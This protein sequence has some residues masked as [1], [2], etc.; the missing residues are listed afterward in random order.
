VLDGRTLN[1][2]QTATMAS[3]GSSLTLADNAV[4]NNNSGASWNLAADADVDGPSGAFN[5]SGTF[6]KTGGTKTST[7]QPAFVNNGAVQANAAALIFAG[8]F[9]Q[10]TGS[11]S[12]G[13][14]A[15][16]VASPAAFTGGSL[17]GQ[18]YVTGAVLNA[19]AIV[20]PGTT[21]VVGKINLTG[22]SGN[23]TQNASGTLRVK[24]GGT[25]VSQYDQLLASEVVT[26]GGT[27]RVSEINGFSPSQG[28]T[29]T[30]IR[31]ASITGQFSTV[32]SGWKVTYKP[33]SVVLTFQ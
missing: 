10:K 15:M 29:F 5:N 21:A 4:V 7:I 1:N 3:K 25:P 20:A 19:S 24:I 31:G 8:N 2:K 33:A 14:G 27:L 17:S 12:L 32:T 23:Y 26:L 18:G 6:K 16:T 30:I 11:T 13:G 28:D 22:S 9:T